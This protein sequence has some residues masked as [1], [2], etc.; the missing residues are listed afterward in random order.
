MKMKTR[1]GMEFYI[2]YAHRLEGH[3]LCGRP[4]GHTAKIIV[5]IEGT[6]KGGQHY[7]DNM[8]M[9]FADMKAICREVLDKLDHHDLNQQFD[10]PTSENITAWIFEQLSKKM[11]VARV[12]FHEGQGKWCSI[13]PS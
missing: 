1:L 5:E 6:V 12:T 10:M 8:V 7:R 3:T 9:D 4:H 13:C 2:D 11:P